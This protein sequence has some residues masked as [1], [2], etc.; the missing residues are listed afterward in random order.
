[1]SK[2]EVRA[3]GAVDESR[4]EI[5]IYGDIGDDWSAETSNDAKAVVRT[6]ADLRGKPIDIRIN[7][8][9]GIVKD[10]L[11]IV[12]AM[13]RH[14]AETVAHVDGVAY[15][16]ASMIAAGASKVCMAENA[17]QMIHAPWAMTVGN[18]ES[19]RKTAETLDGMAKAM[20]SSY[21]RQG[22]PDRDTVTQWLTDGE[23]HY[24]DAAE[25][26]ELGLI[27]E[28]TTRV[29]IAASLNQRLPEKYTWPDLLNPVAKSQQEAAMADEEKDQGRSSDDYMTT[30]ASA[31]KA[32]ELKGGKA[33]NARIRAIAGAFEGFAS[34]DPTD[35]MRALQEQCLADTNVTV[36]EANR[37]ILLALKDKTDI[38][39]SAGLSSAQPA[40]GGVYQTSTPGPVARPAPGGDQID[41]FVDGAT[42]AILIRSGLEKDQKVL[43]E[44]RKG[45]YLSMNLTDMCKASLRV[46]GQPVNGS[47]EDIIR[48]VLAAGGGPG[49]G[50]DHFPAILQNIAEKS[51]MDGFMGAEERWNEWTIPGR[52]NDYREASRV[53]KS[54]FDTLDKMEEFESFQHGR[55]ADVKQSIQGF[56]HGK[57]FSLTLQAIV[58]DDLSILTGDAASWGEAANVT[59]GD[60]VFA[61]IT[62]AQTG[63]FGTLMTETGLATFHATH[64][65]Y[66]TAGAAPDATTLAAART[67]MMTQTDPNGRTVANRPRYIIHSTVLTPTVFPLLTT[68]TLITGEDATVPNRNWVQSLGL[69]SVEEYRMDAWVSA[70]WILAAGRRTV[71]VAFVGGQSS[72][73]VDRMPP[74]E[75]PGVT[76][77]ISIP[78]GVTPLDYRTLYLNDGVT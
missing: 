35:P 47:Q 6:M 71:E 69:Q 39:I 65:N 10:G 78:F 54:L 42:Q 51:V 60:A 46:A 13:Q 61:S 68:Q 28:I 77:Q 22:G 49:Q 66:V 3:R 50:T 45:E 56:L 18:A 44:A 55:F 24:F 16:V 70:A 17:V 1:M 53:N 75:I 12:N 52:L 48:R 2:Y 41:K 67:A 58:N 9:G 30:H 15:S 26:M 76:W 33:E 23:D 64:G 63:G 19:L 74:G 8:Y 57:S 38:P 73:R 32:G 29:D 27:D 11:A 4:A 7:S 21:I 5:L 59:I 34:A 37:R 72:P 62:A 43:A 14:D 25:A 31:V 40:G 36:D 20:T